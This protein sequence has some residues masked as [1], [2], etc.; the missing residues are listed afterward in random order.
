MQ[1]LV[2]HSVLIAL[3]DDLLCL[4]IAQHK[5][6]A[7][8]SIEIE[9][10]AKARRAQISRYRVYRHIVARRCIQLIEL[11]IHIAEQTL[12]NVRLHLDVGIA[13]TCHRLINTVYFTCNA[14]LHAPRELHR[15]RCIARLRSDAALNRFRNRTA[16]KLNRIL[17]RQRSGSQ[18]RCHTGQCAVILRIVDEI[19][20]EGS[21]V[22]RIQGKTSVL[23]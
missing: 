4:L 23:R 1:G 2:D 16:I 7:F 5:D 8:R 6:I 21:V 9:V 11:V 14:D 15:I 19:C 22:I 10:A 18:A 13:C 12:L 20:K 3:N 17:N